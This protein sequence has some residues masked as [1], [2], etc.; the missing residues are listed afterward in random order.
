MLPA[1]FLLL[2]AVPHIPGHEK[3]D[4]LLNG[5]ELVDNYLRIEFRDTINEVHFPSRKVA[6]LKSVNGVVSFANWRANAGKICL[7]LENGRSECWPYLRKF[8]PNKSVIL[9][10]ECGVSSRWTLR[11]STQ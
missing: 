3:S 6:I 4:D 1:Y 9:V 5:S 7:T 8:S 2:L 11:P 10:S